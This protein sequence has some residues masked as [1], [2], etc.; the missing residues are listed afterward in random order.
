[1]MKIEIDGGNDDDD[2]HDDNDDEQLNY[3]FYRGF[4]FEF[5]L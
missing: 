5:C 2:D 1:M 3:I 4:E